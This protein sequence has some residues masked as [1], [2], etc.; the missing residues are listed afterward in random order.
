MARTATARCPDCGESFDLLPEN[1]GKSTAVC[2]RCR[3][4]VVVG[5]TPAPPAA[6]SLNDPS[7]EAFIEPLE[8][9]ED[10]TQVGVASKTLSL[11]PGKRVS[12]AILSGARK[13]DVIF[14]SGPRLTLGRDGGGADVQMPDFE[15]SRS[16]A[17]VECHGARIVLR[18]LGSQNGTFV[19][20]Q[21]VSQREMESHSEFRLGGTTFLLLVADA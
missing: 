7:T 12:I 20:D 19:G 21:R 6:G 17:A 14:L 4:I 8:P 10:P 5:A 15:V 16:H 1:E 3:R 18:D 9:S 11:P 13:G 2:P